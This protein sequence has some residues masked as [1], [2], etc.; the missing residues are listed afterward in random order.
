LPDLAAS[1]ASGPASAAT[2]ETIALNWSATNVGEEDVLGVWNDRVGLYNPSNGGFTG[3]V[4]NE[5][6]GILAMGEGYSRSRQYTVPTWITPGTYRIAAE[7]DL[8]HLLL[9][10]NT[11][12]NLILGSTIVIGGTSG[13][14]VDLESLVVAP[15]DT[16]RRGDPIQVQWLGRNNGP[17]PIDS[18]WRLQFY[19]SP[20][21]TWDSSDRY[22]GFLDVSGLIAPGT[23]RLETATLTVPSGLDSG[24]FHVI[25]RADANNTLVELDEFNNEVASQAVQVTA[26]P[27]LYVT[28]MT[29]DTVGVFGRWLS[30]SWTVRN[31][32]ESLPESEWV[33]R[34]SIYQSPQ[35]WDVAQSSTRAAL[36]RDQE[37]TH[38]MIVPVPPGFSGTSLTVRVA[39]DALDAV[40]ENSESNT[41]SRSI[42]FGRPAGPN[43]VPDAIQS[44]L[45]AT[46]TVPFPIT[47]STR[48]DGEDPVEGQR[49]D[50]VYLSTNTVLDGDDVMVGERTTSEILDLG[51]SEDVTVDVVI[52][53]SITP[54][55]T[56]YLIVETNAD[57]TAA[58]ADYSDNRLVSARLA[59]A[60]DRAADLVL[61]T[62]S[63][64]YSDVMFFG[65]T[66]TLDW[67]GRN[68]G[69][70][71]TE[72]TWQDRVYLSRDAA[73]DAADTRFIAASYQSLEPGQS[74]Q[75]QATGTLPSWAE[76]TG[77]YYLI[78]RV[79]AL[80]SQ[81]E[82]REDNNDL[83]LPVVLAPQPLPD[84]YPAAFTSTSM[85]VTAGEPLG[86][87]WTVTNQGTRDATTDW[88]DAVWLSSDDTINTGDLRLVG[89][90]ISDDLAPGA[91]Y[92]MS[93]SVVIPIADDLP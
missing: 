48:N 74:Y 40:E 86:I 68:D 85:T 92:T 61:V 45:S 91:S 89:Q 62:D 64:L 67:S 24:A 2:G 82:T 44:P 46:A 32:G 76:P 78:L 10:G 42:A 50:R 15:P 28:S 73:W 53:G 13:P 18:T 29:A 11:D 27:D 69:L 39:A 35:W 93:P 80:N 20:D 33:D 8:N 71:A 84:L 87:S 17:D 25:A 7:V 66:I 88:T 51:T 4:T 43:L 41:T 55:V 16:M 59:V 36:Q 38:T 1:A 14:D 77:T 31:Q 79:D 6:A 23:T 9:D 83:V 60:S 3:S 72:G 52:P 63:V 22:M 12:N 58:E 90:Y 21:S 65:D 56:Y 54:S 70:R 5:V 75:R 37:I 81:L 57:R 19:L 49:V 47:W 30:L 34:V 26:R